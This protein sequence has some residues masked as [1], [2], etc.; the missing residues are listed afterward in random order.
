MNPTPTQAQAD[1]I[2]RK[3]IALL[4]Q[5]GLRYVIPA[6]CDQERIDGYLE[7][8]GCPESAEWVIELTPAEFL[9]QALTYARETE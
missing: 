5:K 6:D 8:A 7:N 2:I 3:A 9:A 4:P 1:D